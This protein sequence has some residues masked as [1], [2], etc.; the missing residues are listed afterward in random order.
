MRSI[1]IQED[2]PFA[3]IRLDTPDGKNLLTIP[4][5]EQLQTLLHHYAEDDR[6]KAVILAGNCDYFCF[7][8]ALGNRYEQHSEQ[9][10][11]F[12]R[13]LTSLHKAL[14][15]FPKTTIA[16]V[17]GK[18]GGGGVSLIDACDLA[19]ASE[20]TSFEFPELYNGTA[21]MISLMGVRNSLPKKLCY[22]MMLAKPLLAD[23]LLALGLVNK[24]DGS[25]DVIAAAKKY[26]KQI[27]NYS[28]Q[29]IS[30]CKQYY[31]ATQGL[32]YSQQMEIGKHY[33][34]SMLKGK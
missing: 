28:L 13:S 5:M 17:S 9:I 24:I 18:V 30:L 26:W 32:D 33:L 6:C 19:V 10:L 3:V 7:G 31:M 29:A 20:N 1:Q 16:A 14:V 15:Q 8:G 21:P 27:P 2:F 11:E 23:R 22:E 4:L 25:G 12:A 34:V